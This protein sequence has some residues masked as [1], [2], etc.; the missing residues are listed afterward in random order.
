MHAFLLTGD[1][2]IWSTQWK[3]SCRNK[4]NT[5]T[6]IYRWVDDIETEITSYRHN[7]CSVQMMEVFLQ[8]LAWS[9]CQSK[10][11]IFL[12]TPL[13]YH[14]FGLVCMWIHACEVSCH[15]WIHCC[16][17][18]CDLFSDGIPPDGTPVTVITLRSYAFFTYQFILPGI[19][20][21]CITA[22]FIFTISFRKR[23]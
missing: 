20:L 16:V 18:C 7:C 23:K 3:P 2:W 13:S 10:M 11:V 22:C 6:S 19:T 14:P 5:T 1:N 4:H 9:N 17:L 12:L 8:L 21:I 15:S